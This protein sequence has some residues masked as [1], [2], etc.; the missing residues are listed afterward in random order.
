[1]GFRNRCGSRHQKW[2]LV[3]GFG[4]EVVVGRTISTGSRVQR[5]VDL[6]PLSWGEEEAIQLKS[7][8]TG[9][10]QPRKAELEGDYNESMLKMRWRQ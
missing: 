5:L 9:R 1:M 7:G 2:A 4:S 10:S 6:P 8:C 3:G